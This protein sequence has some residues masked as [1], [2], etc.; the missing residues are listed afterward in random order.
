M[1]DGRHARSAGR[2][3][4]AS[5]T[6]FLEFRAAD[7]GERCFLPLWRGKIPVTGTGFVV[8]PAGTV[9]NSRRAPVIHADLQQGTGRNPDSGA[10]RTAFEFAGRQ[11]GARRWAPEMPY[12]IGALSH[13]KHDRVF[14]Q[15][16]AQ[17]HGVVRVSAKPRLA[18]VQSSAH[19]ASVVIE[20]NFTAIDPARQ[21]GPHDFYLRRFVARYPR[22]RNRDAPE[23]RRSEAGRP[24]GRV[25]ISGLVT[26]FIGDARII[27]DDERRP[28]AALSPRGKHGN[29]GRRDFVGHNRDES[30]R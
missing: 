28:A 10:N 11:C 2:R 27:R 6:Y 9:R 29:D 1:E 3:R 12:T 18:A 22:I 25:H 5:T 30:F 16:K 14:G 26:H 23:S 21:P 13:A 17:R 8:V 24:G 20:D 15:V 19:L 7:I 4:P